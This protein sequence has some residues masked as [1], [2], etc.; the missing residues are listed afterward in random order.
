MDAIEKIG[1]YHAFCSAVRAYKNGCIPI[2]CAILDAGGKVISQAENCQYSNLPNEIIK[3]HPL[4]HAEINAILKTSSYIHKNIASYT[5]FSTLE[6]CPLCFGAIVMGG[7]KNVKFAA[8]DK[9]NE[10]E[11]LNDSLE[12]ISKANINIK[13]PFDRYQ[14]VQ[15]A[16]IVRRRLEKEFDNNKEVIE[17]YNNYCREG[18]QL[19]YYLRNDTHFHQLLSNKNNEKQI[20]DYILSLNENY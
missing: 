3:N 10:F 17:I 18:V 11:K 15:I 7:I 16:L 20:L 2:G 5:L 4:A 8:L 14:I 6:P 1:F 12:F 13:G 9:N 19:G